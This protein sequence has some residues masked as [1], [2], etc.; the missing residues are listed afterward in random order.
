M[1]YSPSAYTKS[2]ECDTTRDDAASNDSLYVTAA[3]DIVGDI[4]SKSL[5]QLHQHLL[6]ITY[7]N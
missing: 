2:G 3:L 6:S 1:Q 5:P 7:D 4:M